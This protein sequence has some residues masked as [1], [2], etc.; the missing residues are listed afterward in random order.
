MPLSYR[1]L[2]QPAIE[3]V[4]LDLAKSHLR[5]DDG[6]T[7]DDGYISGLII[8]ARQLVEKSMNRAI[9]NR[10]MLLTLDYFPWPGW[11]TTGAA[12]AR[13]YFLM[14]YYQ[15]LQIRLPLPSTVSVQSLTYL[16]NDGVTVVTIDPSKYV[17]DT[18]SEPARISPVPGFTWP[19]QQNYIPGQVRVNYTAGTYEIAVTEPFTVPA[20]APYTYTLQQAAALITF[21]GVTDSNNDPVTCTQVDGI[22]TFDESLAGKSYTVSYTVNQC[23]MTIVQA[24]LLLISHLYEHREAVSQ[25]TMTVVPLAVESLLVG[26]TVDSFDW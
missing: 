22:L 24:M 2:S 11:G 26:E 25:A 5:V 4:T 1:A 23:P 3:P 21:T 18:T 14:N 20:A 10:Q 17:V 15:R 13:D 19:Y 7:N 16:A 8:A 12:S 9:F 6:F